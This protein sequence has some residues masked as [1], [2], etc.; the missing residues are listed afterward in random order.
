MVAITYT[1]TTRANLAKSRIR[2]CAD[3]ELPNIKRN[4]E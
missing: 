1:A 2:T 4:G 3:H